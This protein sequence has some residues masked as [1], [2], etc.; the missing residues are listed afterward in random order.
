MTMNV[1]WTGTRSRGPSSR[2]EREMEEP[3]Q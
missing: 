1:R 2:G 3:E